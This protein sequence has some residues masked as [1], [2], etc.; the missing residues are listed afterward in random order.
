MTITRFRTS[1]PPW[2]PPG[3]AVLIVVG[4]LIAAG[5][6]IWIGEPASARGATGSS[7]AAEHE[8]RGT[9]QS[10]IPQIRSTSFS[11]PSIVT[12]LATRPAA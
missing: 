2:Q 7:R 12:G 11:R 6:I 1:P 5:L 4:A 9:D 10:G 8:L 3:F